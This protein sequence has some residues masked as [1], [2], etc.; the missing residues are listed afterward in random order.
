M[1][2]TLALLVSVAGGSGW[3]LGTAG[4]LRRLP[5]ADRVPG[6]L[7]ARHY[8]GYRLDAHQLFVQAH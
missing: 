6:G 3:S 4:V 2:F 8:Q 1:R 7:S 5:T